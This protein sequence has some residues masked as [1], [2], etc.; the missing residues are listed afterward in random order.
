MRHGGAYGSV[1]FVGNVCVIRFFSS[2]A[3]AYCDRAP[4][5]RRTRADRG[6]SSCVAAAAR[7][8]WGHY[9]RALARLSL[10]YRQVCAFPLLFDLLPIAV[11]LDHP[12]P[13]RL[14]FCLRHVPVRELG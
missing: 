10:S 12:L 1:F 11:E 7:V 3:S 2:T 9:R 14:L 13:M 6:A 8:C 5:V 4:P